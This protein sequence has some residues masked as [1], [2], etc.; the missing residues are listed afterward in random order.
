ME[1]KFIILAVL[2]ILFVLAVIISKSGFSKKIKMSEKLFLVSNFVLLLC[3]GGGFILTI[4]IGEEILSSHIFEIILIPALIA[5]VVT[6]ISTKDENAE[7]QYDEKQKSDMKDAATF[8][9]MLII[10]ATFLLYTFY[11]SGTLTGLIFFPL[12]LFVAFISY[13]GSLLY[14]Y[15]L[16]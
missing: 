2:I 12:I 7:E 10:I 14:F 11:S 6:G 9:W 4:F 8:S 3:S 1:V 16:G 5:F 13:A 15:K